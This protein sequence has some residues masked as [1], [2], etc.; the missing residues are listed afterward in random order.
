MNQS[1]IEKSLSDYLRRSDLQPS[2]EDVLGR[3]VRWFGLYAED[4]EPDKVNYGHLDD[5][6]S[7]LKAG[8]P[9]EKR[10]SGRTVNTYMA[11]MSRFFEWMFERGYIEKNPCRC[12][13]RMKEEDRQFD[14]YT[15]D[16]VR[17]ILKV[18]DLRFA[19][20]ICL[21]LCSMR[22][23]EI[24]NLTVS[25]IDFGN[26]EIRIRGKEKSQ[27]TWPWRIKNHQESIV[28]I[29][30]SVAQLLISLTDKLEG[31]RQPYVILKPE[32]WEG[33]MK[34]QAEGKLPYWRCNRPWDG[35]NGAYSRLLRRAGVPHKRFHD[36]RS[37]FATE[38]YEAGFKLVDVQE[39]MRHKTVQTTA[40][41]IRGVD[42]R[43][44]AKKS[45]GIFKKFYETMVS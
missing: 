28:G 36:H 34:R 11:M 10:R 23:S 38:R 14:I 30:E 44:L 43:K 31:S 5:F 2:S 17:K 24:L 6:Q 45:A 33:N 21:A 15:V 19:A 26:L 37:T 18:C 22:R 32:H 42:K 41:Y 39:L 9:G 35:F 25:D 4:I 16:E 40:L 12:L 1:A 8:W 3:A 7:A 27:T 13:K 20:V 29:D